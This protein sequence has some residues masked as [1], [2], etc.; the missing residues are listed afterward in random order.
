MHKHFTDSTKA[1][2]YEFT[3][4]PFLSAYALS[5]TYWNMK[6]FLIFFSDKLTV[7]KKIEMLSWSD[8]D[9]TSPLLVG[10]FFVFAYPIAAALFYAVTL[11]YR[12]QMN[13]IQQR[14]QD[15]T[16]L[17]QE[18]ANEI[19][20]ENVK[21]QEDLHSKNEK[22]S[23]MKLDY[24]GKEKILN[25]SFDTKVNEK[26]LS[27]VQEQTDKLT[28]KLNKLTTDLQS[29]IDEL[30]EKEIELQSFKDDNNVLQITNNELQD[31][32]KSLKI[33]PKE[34]TNQSGLMREIQNNFDKKIPTLSTGEKNVL[35][36]FSDNDSTLGIDF[37]KTQMKAAFKTNKPIT[38]LDLKTLETKKI[39]TFIGNTHAKLTELG[40]NCVK[41]LYNS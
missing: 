13:G 9:Y 8:V 23:T 35:K 4:T 31:K 20:K 16:P 14:I 24:D 6:L 1:R 29:K 34:E 40:L 7:T 10:L 18:K 38:E 17:P 2:L 33:K 15:I 30:S 3:Y 41:Y 36:V 37:L 19:I 32:V 5:W 25:D 11:W 12:A 27:D 22:L 26:V 28:K 21:L 39:L